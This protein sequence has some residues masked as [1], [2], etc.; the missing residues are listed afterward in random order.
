MHCKLMALVLFFSIF[1]SSMHQ[2]LLAQYRIEMPEYGFSFELSDEATL[3]EHGNDIIMGTGSNMS[4]V[5]Q[6]FDDSES[7]TEFTQRLTFELGLKIYDS[8]YVTHLKGFNG[9]ILHG[10]IDDA[11]HVVVYLNDGKYK[12]LINIA[13]DFEEGYNEATDLINSIQ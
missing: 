10:E 7:F 4:F 11:T 9:M 1:F 12:F 13:W 2:H 8:G 6:A 3:E 5:I